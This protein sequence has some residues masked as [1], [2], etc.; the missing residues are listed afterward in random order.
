MGV[1]VVVTVV[2]FE[3]GGHAANAAAAMIDGPRGCSQYRCTLR[4]DQVIR[5]VD[6]AV[7]A[8]RTEVIDVSKRPAKWAD[9]AASG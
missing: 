4:R 9:D 5:S 1:E 2:A 6:T 3:V 7:Y 8:G